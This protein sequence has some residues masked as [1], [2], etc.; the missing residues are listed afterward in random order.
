MKML[1]LNARGESVV[2]GRGRQ[3]ERTSDCAV[4]FPS[5]ALP[6]SSGR[7]ASLDRGNCLPG[8]GLY[9]NPVCDRLAEG[10][11]AREDHCSS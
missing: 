9:W 7:I 11:D 1:D 4:E 6:T 5:S 10:F 3:T 8:G 2:I